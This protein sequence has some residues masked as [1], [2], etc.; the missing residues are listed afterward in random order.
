M[1]LET[2][3]AVLARVALFTTLGDDQLRLIAFGAEPHELAAG[4]ELCHTGQNADGAFVLISGSL[5]R[6]VEDGDAVERR[7]SEPG[8]LIGELSL[9]TQCV[10]QSTVV[11]ETSCRLLRLPRPLFRRILEEYPKTALELRERITADLSRKVR[12]MEAA[13]KGLG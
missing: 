9:L 13:S 1:A 4:R 6:L 3:M 12:L 2:D 8:T 5:A 10:W 11:A 7:F